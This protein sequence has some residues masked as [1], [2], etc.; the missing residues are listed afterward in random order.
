MRMDVA[1][2]ILAAGLAL[3]SY[4]SALLWAGNTS[5]LV[6]DLGW[7]GWLAGMLLLGGTAIVGL[8]ACSLTANTLLSERNRECSTLSDPS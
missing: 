1:R 5:N 3:A 4:P 6:R 2:F 7:G 8:L